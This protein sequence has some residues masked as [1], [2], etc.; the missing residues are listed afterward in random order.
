MPVARWRCPSTAIAARAR[1]SS[2][3][4]RR[5]VRFS[6]SSN[7]SIASFAPPQVHQHFADL[8]VDRLHRHRRSEFEW[9]CGLDHGG[10]AGEDERLFAPALGEQEHRFELLGHHL[11]HA[12]VAAGGAAHG[13]PHRRTAVPGV[14]K[15][16]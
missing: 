7:A 11:R 5:G 2:D 9:E 1:P 12:G 3:K 6:D 15:V 10:L 14:S 13:H 16:P 8:L 4:V